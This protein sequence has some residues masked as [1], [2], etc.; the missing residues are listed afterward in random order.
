MKKCLPTLVGLLIVSMCLCFIFYNTCNSAADI[1][2]IQ[3]TQRCILA[4]QSSLV[5]SNRELMPSVNNSSSD[6]HQEM[7]TVLSQRSNDSISLPYTSPMQ[8]RDAAI[9]RPTSAELTRA[10][11]LETAQHSMSPSSQTYQSQTPSSVTSPP[12][13]TAVTNPFIAA[14]STSP[15]SDSIKRTFIITH[16]FGGQLTRAVKNMMIQQCWAQ[17]LPNTA[18]IL[19]PFSS[20]S[21]LLH[22]PEI[23]DSVRSGRMKNAARFSDF[24]DLKLYNHVSVEDGG[25]PLVMWEE[26]LLRA[27]RQVVV[28]PTPPASCSLLVNHHLQT[29]LDR[30]FKAFL[31]GLQTWNFNIVKVFPINCYNQNRGKK[32][33]EMMSPYLLNSTI[34][35]S[36]WRNYNVARTWLDLDTRCN[37]S[38]K[39]PADRL[40]PSHKMKMH[41]KYY[42]TNIL[43]AEKTIAIM[44]RVERFL[45]LKQRSSTRLMDETVDSCLDK[46]LSLFSQLKQEPIW[47]NSQPFLTLD[48]GRYGSGIMQSNETVAKFGESLEAVTKSVTALLVKVYNG[49][50]GSIREWED[51]FVD[52]TEGI[53]E[54]GYVAM[55]QR[56]IAVQSD[57]LILMGGGS[58]QEVAAN[59]YLQAH[60]DPAQQCLHTVCA[61]TAIPTSLEK[62]QWKNKAPHKAKQ[63]YHKN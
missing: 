36:S 52:A 49:R 13:W 18:A 23:W 22:T 19:E 54:R 4:R 28:V 41:M 40:L 12:S 57:C 48:I 26:F 63:K 1:S 30:D 31:K 10:A 43:G 44:L 60:P 5:S 33:I 16:S 3:G 14:S 51:S 45:C 58:F 24:F 20:E 56:G 55:L 37:I 21:L 6:V 42:R 17:S 32:L 50:W 8:S 53:T 62:S 38:D 34:A 59:Q 35:F 25:V 7:S 29:I 27:P 11:V 15:S 46:T 39:Y 2:A 47:A 61:A 9:A